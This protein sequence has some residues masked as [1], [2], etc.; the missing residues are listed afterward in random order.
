M[1][2]CPDNDDMD[3]HLNSYSVQIR[4]WGYYERR[5]DIVLLVK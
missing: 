5:E 1:S 3:K 4:D 2:R